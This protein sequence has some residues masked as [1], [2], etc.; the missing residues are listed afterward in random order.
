MASINRGDNTGAFGNDFLRIYLNNP[1]NLHIQ[2]AL[3]QINGDLEKEFY[4]PTFPIRINFT[5]AE[6]EILHQVNV[7][8]LVLWDEYGRR[9][10]ADG[11]FTFFVKENPINSP[12]APTI[13]DTCDYIEDNSIVFNL[14]DA[15]FAAQF[16]INATPTKLSELDADVPYLQP[17]NIKNGRNV[18]VFRDGNDVI[19]EADIAADMSY[20]NLQDLPTING[21]V[22]KGDVTI[23]AEQV[24]ADWEAVEGKA[25]ILNKPEFADVAFT[26]NAADLKNMPEIPRKTSQLVNDTN[27]LT[28]SVLVDYATKDELNEVVNKDVDLTDVYAKI[29]ELAQKENADVT[30]L[31]ELLANTVDT[32]TL[33]NVIGALKQKDVELTNIVN[34]LTKT[35][36]G[37][38]TKIDGIVT[39]DDIAPLKDKLD[40]CVTE[41]EVD[42]KLNGYATQKELSDGLYNKLNKTSLHDGILTI[43]NNGE[44]LGQFTANSNKDVT[45]DL[46]VP[47]KLSELE[48]DAEYVTRSEVSLDNL[49]TQPELKSLANSKADKKEI[50]K[51]IL[52][53][54]VNNNL[55]GSFN[56]NA[57]EDKTIN[58]AVP[59]KYSDLDADVEYLVTEDLT[60]LKLD[61]NNLTGTVT[62][63]TTKI[64]KLES[65]LDKKLDKQAGYALMPVE[66]ITRLASVDNYDDTELKNDFKAVKDTVDNFDTN[67]DNKVDKIDGKGLS[68][69]DYTTDEKNT[70]ALTHSDLEI[71]KTDILQDKS[72]IAD[73]QTKQGSLEDTVTA[74]TADVA[75]KFESES[76]A[77]STKDNELQAQIEALQAK[78][79]VV[80]ILGDTEEL[81]KYDRTRLSENDVICVLKDSLHNDTVSY[82]RWVDHDLAY[83]GS[84]GQHYTKSESDERFISSSTKINGYPITEDINL[85]CKDVNALCADTI[86]GEG[87]VTLYKK[88]LNY[89]ANSMNLEKELSAQVINGSSDNYVLTLS[90][91]NIPLEY[92]TEYVRF[93]Y[94]A[95]EQKLLKLSLTGLTEEQN[96][97]LIIG[98]WQ[99]AAITFTG[100]SNAVFLT[101]LNNTLFKQLADATWLETVIGELE[102]EQEP[103]EYAQ[104]NQEVTDKLALEGLELLGTFGANDTTNTVLQIAIPTD[105][106]DLENKSEFITKDV[107]LD[108]YLGRDIP[109][110]TLI[111]DEIDTIAARVE[112][113][114]GNLPAVALDGQYYSL[115]NLPTTISSN[116]KNIKQDPDYTGYI[117]NTFIA[118]LKAKSKFLT[119]EDADLAD[120]AAKAEI[121]IFVSQLENDRGYITLNAVGRADITVKLA[122]E[123]LNTFNANTKEEVTITIPVDKEMSLTSLNPVENKV[124]KATI[125]DLD[126]R[127]VHLTLDETVNGTKTI[128]SLL[129]DT[130]ATADSSKH[131]ATTEYVK[132]QDYCT[133]TAAVHKD[134]TE[135]I[136]GEKTFSG[137]VLLQNADGVT[138]E[139]V[140]NSTKLATTAFVKN[141][142]YS[143]NFETVHKTGDETINGD[144][145]FAETTTFQGI[146]YLGEYAHVN[147]PDG[148]VLDAVVSVEY[149]DNKVNDLETAVNTTFTHYYDKD[150]VDSK[151]SA[152]NGKIAG[153]YTKL[154]VD[155]LLQAKE[156]KIQVLEQTVQALIARIEA[157]EATDPIE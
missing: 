73:L 157:L 76:N 24:N 41:E 143:T 32:A 9:K 47:A 112:G 45:I 38:G 30:E 74:L 60:P 149:A 18:H 3:I 142:D 132:N 50:G 119:I 1:N 81:A 96:N 152:L 141:Q 84:E 150:A 99:E 42:N 87:K 54:Q 88:D 51:G 55:V 140:D 14:S 5:G 89:K 11:K 83:I 130:Q 43:A 127:V 59:T 82:Y 135:T 17:E 147:T 37:F 91:Y 134:L 61:I 101:H 64:N 128:P 13:D 133:N 39:Q 95:F 22:L 71:A 109:A 40:T 93:I 70:L 131:V 102:E 146:T 113:L 34:L 4:D 63:H 144:K 92:P 56:A 16:T 148:T 46:A 114:E 80:D 48:N 65:N 145:T 105:L 124:V 137:H 125:D 115:R 120:F 155:G 62:N 110:N 129:S 138:L 52:S 118:E 136:T 86:I 67:I 7:C 111:Q 139:N 2:R 106:N 153:C 94:K 12:D 10:T 23:E 66:E 28:P 108:K 123:V 36:D 21:T 97:N 35:V 68:T 19:I 31:K 8:K 98:I 77:R 103:I 72:D 117:D 100:T 6:T 79:D 75:D 20:N 53:V 27:F 85:T 25:L 121:P 57:M 104:L 33:N 122:D 78:S 44:A 154:E 156:N 29:D 69:N 58:V 90:E 15:E 49:V 126:S 26:G 151:E 116:Y 107:L